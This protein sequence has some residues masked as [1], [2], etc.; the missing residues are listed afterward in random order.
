MR[1]HEGDTIELIDGKGALHL[2]RIDTLTKKEAHL[3]ILETTTTPPK[4]PL[5]TLIQ[6]LPATP[7]KLKLILEKGTELGIDAFHF[8]GAKTPSLDKLHTTLIGAIKQCGRLHLPSLAFHSHLEDIPLS[9]SYYGDP[10]GA[11]LEP[12]RHTFV[13]GPESGFTHTE[14]AHLNAQKSLPT[15]LSN[16]ILR[17]E[18]AAIIASHLLSIT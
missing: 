11:Q 13:I 12:G 6:G 10:Q 18:T 4:D 3:T 15:R 1:N 14:I 5:K 2:A 16:H 7:N 17:T 8:F 9:P